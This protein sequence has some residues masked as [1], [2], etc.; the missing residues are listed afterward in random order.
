M[1]PEQQAR[2]LLERMEIEGAQSFSSGELVELANLIADRD[3][4]KGIVPIYE[5]IK[6]DANRYLKLRGLANPG[7]TSP[8]G[9]LE[10][11]VTR[12]SLDSVYSEA[13]F[14]RIIDERE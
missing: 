9:K 8:R 3:R 12:N 1:T 11:F 13:M 14:D 7:P 4:L 10:A 2:D 6:A 5:R